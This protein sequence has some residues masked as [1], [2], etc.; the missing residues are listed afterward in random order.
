MRLQLQSERLILRNL[1]ESDLDDFL[2]YRANPEVTRFQSF[3]PYNRRQAVDFIASQKD[4]EYGIPGQW[5]QLGVIEIKSN[6]LIGDCAVRLDEHEP[7]IAELGCTLSPAFQKKGYAKEIMLTL[8][9][10]LFEQQDIHRIVE[11]TDAENISSIRLLESIGF[12]REGLFVENIWFK[13]KWGS[14]YQYAMLKR[15]WESSGYKK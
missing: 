9:R 2:S 15:E 12:R 3:E 7:R 11:I 6:R 8:M 5:L 13:G 4:K 10:F 1:S 14:E